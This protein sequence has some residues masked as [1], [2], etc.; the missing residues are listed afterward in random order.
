MY[1]QHLRQQLDGSTVCITSSDFKDF[2]FN[3]YISEGFDP[4]NCHICGKIFVNGNTLDRHVKSVHL[5]LEKSCPLCG[6]KFQKHNSITMFLRHRKTHP[7]DE[8]VGSRYFFFLVSEFGWKKI[9][10]KT[11]YVSMHRIN[12]G[13]KNIALKTK[14]TKSISIEI[15]FVMPQSSCTCVGYPHKKNVYTLSISHYH[16]TFFQENHNTTLSEISAIFLKEKARKKK[17]SRH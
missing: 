2:S 14:C 11:A 1:R 8:L 5:G 7:E 4:N 6:V 3:G 10:L 13:R 12:F 15:M 16:F 17:A 9:A